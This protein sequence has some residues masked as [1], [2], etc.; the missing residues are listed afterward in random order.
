M[1][2]IKSKIANLLRLAR[3]PSWVNTPEG[4][5]AQG[6]A[7][8]LM[9][10]HGLTENDF[11]LSA[12]KLDRELFDQ[13]P[14]PVPWREMLLLT[15]CE[16]LHGGVVSPMYHNGQWQLWV[17][18]DDVN[19]TQ[20]RDHYNRLAQRIEN[21]IDIKWRHSQYMFSK[22][23]PHVVKRRMEGYALGAMTHVGKAILNYLREDQMRDLDVSDL[24]FVVTNMQ[25]QAAQEQ[26]QPRHVDPIEAAVAKQSGAFER[27][28]DAANEVFQ[29]AVSVPITEIPD[30]DFPDGPPM[31]V[32]EPDRPSFEEGRA[33]ANRFIGSDV[34]PD[35]LLE[36]R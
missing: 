23:P 18:G 11:Q 9:A 10:K 8:R 35:Y 32:L 12:E 28:I 7:Q 5:N 4:A 21:V 36:H 16:V 20:L 26:A 34:I 3:D 1:S 13:Y 29:R 33:V 31:K 2:R 25:L 17:A 15:L 27:Q 22:L 19:F 30:P 6:H 14:E 24:P